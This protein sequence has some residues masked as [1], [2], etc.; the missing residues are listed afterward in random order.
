MKLIS[1][2]TIALGGVLLHT[3]NAYTR[4][5]ETATDLLNAK[6]K[7]LIAAVDETVLASLL[8]N[9]I[10]SYEEGTFSTASAIWGYYLFG[11]IPYEG[12]RNEVFGNE[13]IGT[14]G[15]YNDVICGAHEITLD[16]CRQEPEVCDFAKYKAVPTYSMKGAVFL[17][18]ENTARVLCASNSKF[19]YTPQ[20]CPQDTVESL[21]PNAEGLKNLINMMPDG[22]NN[23]L[24]TLGT[25]RPVTYFDGVDRIVA[26][27]EA[28]IDARDELYD[29]EMVPITTVFNAIG[30]LGGFIRDTYSFVN[31]P[32]DPFA[33]GAKQAFLI[34][35]TQGYL[36]QKYANEWY[37]DE[38]LAEVVPKFFDLIGD[39]ICEI[40]FGAYHA[41]KC[42]SLADFLEIQDQVL[43]EIDFDKDN[44]LSAC[45]QMQNDGRYN[46]V[47]KTGL[48]T[49]SYN[50]GSRCTNGCEDS[51]TAFS[52]TGKG[53]RT[54]DWAVRVNK[55]GKNGVPGRCSAYPEVVKNCPDTCKTCCVAKKKGKKKG[56]KT[57]CELAR[58]K[59]T[60]W[61]SKKTVPK[62]VQSA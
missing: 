5:K 11:L 52:V 43:L 39:N 26:L 22:A 47:M 41:W 31:D 7:K 23:P 8:E 55:P 13:E 21:I 24:L 33:F 17:N 1:P 44:E 4:G 29:E 59:K 12:C 14:D 50:I 49:M 32:K 10:I 37:T 58:R 15:K 16:L 60:A 20:S 34:Y 57:N 18:T 35:S 9:Q 6:V 38:E 42:T 36:Y 45:G 61:R 40:G 62:S 54:C 53:M 27:G 51:T 19:A 48:N 3:Q 28:L 2:L 25:I 46:R 30:Y 56:L